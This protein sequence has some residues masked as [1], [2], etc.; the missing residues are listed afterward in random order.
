[1]SS[2]VSA[3]VIDFD[4]DRAGASYG[5]EPGY[6]LAELDLFILKLENLCA[7]FTARA[8]REEGPAIIE[9]PGLLGAKARA[10]DVMLIAFEDVAALE[11]ELPFFGPSDACF[12]GGG[13]I[14]TASGPVA[15]MIA[16]ILAHGRSSTGAAWA[17]FVSARMM[18]DD[19]PV[20]K[21]LKATYKPVGGAVEA[22]YYREEGFEAEVIP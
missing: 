7:S 5:M 14:V 11:E 20:R 13:N 6:T 2:R 17:S 12:D 18:T 16:Y 3:E 4:G 8:T 21:L 15:E 1:M 19:E 9:E 10:S 22:E